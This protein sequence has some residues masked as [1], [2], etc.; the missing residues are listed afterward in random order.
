MLYQLSYAGALRSAIAHSDKTRILTTGYEKRKFQ[1][2]KEQAARFAAP[3][4]PLARVIFPLSRDL[5]PG[6]HRFGT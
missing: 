4:R 1:T 5:Y 3:T 2:A 6:Y